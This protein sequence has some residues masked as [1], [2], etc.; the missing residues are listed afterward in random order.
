MLP[1]WTETRVRAFRTSRGIAVYREGERQERNELTLQEA[2]RGPAPRGPRSRSHASRSALS[3]DACSRSGRWPSTFRR[4]CTWQ[5]CTTPREPKTSVMARRSPGAPSIEQQRTA[6]SAQVAQQAGRRPPSPWR[7]RASRAR[8]SGP[9]RRSSGVVPPCRQCRQV[10][11][12]QR[13]R[14]AGAVS[15]GR[16]A[17]IPHCSRSPAQSP[18]RHRVQGAR[19]GAS[20]PPPR[21]RPACARPAGRSP[22]P[23][24]SSPAAPRPRRSANRGTSPCRPPS[25]T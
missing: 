15:T 5:R 8:V 3:T 19:S 9:R 14:P 16:T 20:T 6:G 4:L 22:P 2:A 23:I 21:P 13:P 18:R 11:L 1:T 12:P 24:R 25:T 17:A 7:L 10:H